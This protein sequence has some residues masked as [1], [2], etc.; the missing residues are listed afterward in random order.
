MKTSPKLLIIQ[1]AF[2]G[3]VILATS[4]IEY[5]NQTL[6]NYEIHFLLRDGNQSLLSTNPHIKKMFI[7]QKKSHKYSSLLTNLFLIRKEK[8]EVLIN[9]QRFFSSGLLTALSGANT[10]IG[11]NKNP[12][13]F[14]FSHKVMHKIPH[15]HKNQFLHEVQ[16]NA[17][18]TKSLTSNFEIPHYSNLKP[19]LY[20]DKNDEEKIENLLPHNN[21]D[22]FVLAPS[23]VWYTKQWHAS[24]WTELIK[25]LE[26]IGTPYIIGGP[27]DSQYL[28]EVI[29]KDS[30]AINLSGKLSLRQSALL[31]KKAKRVFVNDSAPL[32]LASSV[33]AQTTAIFCSTVPDFGYFPLSDESRVIQ[34]SPR[35]SCMPCGLHGHNNCPKKHF[36]CSMEISVDDVY[37]TI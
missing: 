34:L 24:K 28:S 18:L 27:S 9:I 21:M 7:W 35:L 6:P 16:R 12:L 11:F 14:L 29:P 2:I 8:Y 33:N 25:K 3:D 22:Y 13:S 15:M 17:L 23:S 4:L 5:I 36:H 31:M 30:K 19:R 20:F 37:K 1:T 26:L 32:H 10:K